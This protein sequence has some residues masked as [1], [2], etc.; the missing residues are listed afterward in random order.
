MGASWRTP[1]GPGTDLEGRHDHPVVHVS[2]NDAVAFASCLRASR[3]SNLLGM[4]GLY[5]F[6]SEVGQ[7]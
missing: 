4:L 7:V 6:A 2:W 5:A 3:C 1:E